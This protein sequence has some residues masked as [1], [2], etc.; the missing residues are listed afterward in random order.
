[1]ST[2]VLALVIVVAFVAGQL[3]LLRPNPRE[4]RL[5]ALRA[6]ARQQGLQPRLVAPPE[7]YRGPRPAGGLLACY[8][9]LLGED[10]KG[11]AYVRAERTAPGRWEVRAG[12]AD[13]LQGI[14]L[15]PAAESLIALETRANAASLWWVEGLGEEALPSLQELLRQLMSKVQKIQ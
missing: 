3:L 15:P 6:A 2:F 5:M 7:W 10:E 9:L 1:M 14:E 13:V 11:L 4:K 12:P 8:S